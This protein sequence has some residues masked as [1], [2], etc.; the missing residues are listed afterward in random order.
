MAHEKA[1]TGCSGLSGTQS[2]T[3]ALRGM[4][5]GL[6]SRRYLLLYRPPG[7]LGQADDDGHTR[8]CG[9][10]RSLHKRVS[11]RCSLINDPEQHGAIWF[12]NPR[13]R[14]AEHDPH[15]AFQGL[16]L[17]PKRRSPRAFHQRL[18]SRIHDRWQQPLPFQP[19]G[20]VLRL[21]GRLKPARTA[22]NAPSHW[23]KSFLMPSSGTKSSSF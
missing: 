19:Q 11:G 8:S 16:R 4:H 14:D 21:A 6:A 9:T 3:D 17:S 7:S 10:F 20:G 15:H 13:V 18:I 5:L 22:T 1:L 12:R 23:P 2:K